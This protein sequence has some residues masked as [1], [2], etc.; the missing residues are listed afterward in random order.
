MTFDTPEY[1]S[2]TS[3]GDDAAKSQRIF[4]WLALLSDEDLA[5]QRRKAHEPISE[6]THPVTGYR[7]AAYAR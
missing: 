2:R 5:E 6:K 4:D 7:L 1:P 3:S